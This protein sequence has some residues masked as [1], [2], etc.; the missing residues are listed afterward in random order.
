MLVGRLHNLQIRRTL[1]PTPRNALDKDRVPHI[2]ATSQSWSP[3]IAVKTWGGLRSD[4]LEDSSW[5]KYS[6]CI[7]IEL[8]QIGSKWKIQW[9]LVSLR[10]W[11]KKFRW[12]VNFGIPAAQTATEVNSVMVSH[13]TMLQDAANVP[14]YKQ[15]R[16]YH[17]LTFLSFSFSFSL[18]LSILILYVLKC[19][20][21]LF[22]S[23]SFPKAILLCSSGALEIE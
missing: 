22:F 8:D 5:F 14:R 20:L 16:A 7:Q 19:S 1:S 12:D 9:H 4:K 21:L 17:K 6:N 10:Q 23:L 3:A 13:T 15:S 2:H 18:S 11:R